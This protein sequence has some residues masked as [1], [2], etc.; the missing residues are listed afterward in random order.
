LTDRYLA[1]IN[2]DTPLY[3]SRNL[4]LYLDYLEQQHPQADID[5][6]LAHARISHHELDDIGHWFSQRQTDRFQE[7]VD[8][9]TADPDVARLAGRYA[10][11]SET[12][13]PARQYLLSL[14]NPASVYLLMNKLSKIWSRG[15][16]IE[17]RR[18]GRNR[19]ELTSVPVTGVE[20]KLYQC[21]NRTGIFEAIAANF[22]GKL[23]HIEHPECFHRGDPCCRYIISWVQTPALTWKMMRNFIAPVGL[24]AAA[25]GFLTLPFFQGVLLLV[26]FVAAWLAV[27]FYAESI[28]NR[29]LSHRIKAQGNA[30]KDLLLEIN[31]RT[32][33]ALITK[34][35]GQAAAG[36]TDLDE[37]LRSVDF[38]LKQ[39]LNY[40]RGIIMLE[41]EKGE[42]LEY[43]TGFG[44]LPEDEAYLKSHPF[45][46]RMPGRKRSLSGSLKKNAHF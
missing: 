17:A 31:A 6:I 11:Q 14:V 25:V 18:L 36:A 16:T 8:Q 44:L 42:R 27:G 37:L 20:E 9:Q 10:A 4:K 43:R 38:I 7:I 32:N 22:T 45:N 12:G 26:G 34:E 33:D 29:E 3:N 15:A 35:I 5:A 41:D 40:D 21:H 13:G 24:L 19:V 1:E 30:A 2:A 46:L 23:A 39:H 28:Q